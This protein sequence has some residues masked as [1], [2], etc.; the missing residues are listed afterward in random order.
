MSGHSLFQWISG[1][2]VLLWWLAVSSA[3]MFFATL[4]AL[5]WLLVIIPADYFTR[6][7]RRRRAEAIRH[8]VLRLLARIGRNLF[9]LILLLVGA[10]MLVLPGQGVLTIL[11]GLVFLDFPGKWRIEYWIIS[12][13]SIRRSI[14]WLRQR[15]GHPPLE[16]EEREWGV[17]PKGRQKAE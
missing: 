5:P 9:G 13:P 11:A 16:R 2:G 8:P 10:V 1:H 3:V 12:R 4:I 6:A 14:N 17:R 7:G 15:R